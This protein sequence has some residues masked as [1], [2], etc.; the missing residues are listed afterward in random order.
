MV[1]VEWK[2]KG[3]SQRGSVHLS[4]LPIAIT[5]VTTRDTNARAETL[6]MQTREAVR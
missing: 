1:K 5:Q 4:S 3:K 2:A 6:N